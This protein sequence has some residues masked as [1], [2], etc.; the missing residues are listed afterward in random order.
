MRQKSDVFQL[1]DIEQ[2]RRNRNSKLQTDREEEHTDRD[3]IQRVVQTEQD[4]TTFQR[5][6]S[7]TSDVLNKKMILKKG[8]DKIVNMKKLERIFTD[9]MKNKISQA[10][11]QPTEKDLNCNESENQNQFDL[12]RPY[13]QQSQIF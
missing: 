10:K 7:E 13:S 11:T 5:Q 3:N 8:V 4:A 2:G 6:F 9:G 1:I 12:D